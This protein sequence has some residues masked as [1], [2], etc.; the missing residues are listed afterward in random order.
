MSVCA[1]CL[2]LLA[3]PIPSQSDDG[4]VPSLHPASGVRYPMS[5]VEGPLPYTE[6]LG[7][8][9]RLHSRPAVY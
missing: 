2:L 3:L 8:H 1:L 6:V 4:E 9:D 5:S 7:P